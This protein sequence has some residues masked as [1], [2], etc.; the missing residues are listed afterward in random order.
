MPIGTVLEFVQFKFL[1]TPSEVEQAVIRLLRHLVERLHNADCDGQLHLFAGAAMATLT[2]AH[3]ELFNRMPDEC[4]DSFETLYE[5]CDAQRQNSCDLWEPPD[6]FTLTHD[7]TL[8]VNADGSELSL[9]DW[10]FSQL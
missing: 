8:C 7:M 6:K 3:E 5:H 4:Y 1:T 9:N 10:S 2:K